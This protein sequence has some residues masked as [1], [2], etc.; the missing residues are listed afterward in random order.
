MKILVPGGAGYVGAV[1]VPALLARGHDVVVFDKYIYGK[2][3]FDD[4]KISSKLT[5]IEG[6]VRNPTALYEAAMGCEKVIHLACI[7]NDPTCALDP[8]L[9]KD[10]N[11]DSFP[12]QLNA[13]E[14]AGIKHLIFAS[15][16]SVYGIAG[17]EDVDELAPRV[18][19]SDYNSYKAACEDLLATFSAIPYTIIRPATLCG[20]SPRQRLDLVVNILA[21]QSVVNNEISVFGGGQWRPYLSVRDMAKVYVRV[22]EEKNATLT[23]NQT[24]N[25]AAG[26]I[27]VEMIASIVHIVRSMQGFQIGINR[28][29]SNDPR[30][31]RVNTQKFRKAFSWVPEVPLKSSVRE[32]IAAFEDGRLPRDALSDSRFTNIAKMKEINLV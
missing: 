25:V 13:F 20:Y 26:N 18:P 11:L 5:E 30:S 24:Y 12:G 9:A 8:K 17:D 6:D 1:L 14:E 10:I 23:M 22:A 16:S 19:V 3:V 21:A 2:H 27:T 7:S 15:S 28:V 4:I 32:V 29:E 31:Y